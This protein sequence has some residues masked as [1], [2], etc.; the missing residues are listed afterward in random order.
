MNLSVGWCALGSFE[1]IGVRRL[2]VKPLSQL[3]QSSVLCLA[4]F[5]IDINVTCQVVKHIHYLTHNLYYNHPIPYDGSSFNLDFLQHTIF[6][7]LHY[8][9]LDVVFQWLFGKVQ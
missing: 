3:G 7:P 5:D 4:A 2:A 9:Q 6:D 1:L 8:I